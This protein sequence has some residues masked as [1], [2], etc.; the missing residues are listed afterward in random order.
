MRSASMA[1]P[2]V[3]GRRRNP[4]EGEYPF[5]TPVFVDGLT[6]RTDLNGRGARVCELCPRDT[7]GRIGIQLLCDAHTRVW[8]KKENLTALSFVEELD[9]D[10][11]RKMTDAERMDM[12]MYMDA[13]RGAKAIPG[14]KG[15][16]VSTFV[17]DH[18]LTE[19]EKAELLRVGQWGAN[20][21]P[22]EWGDVVRQIKNA[23]N[24][25]YP[26][27]WH[28]AIVNGDLFVANGQGNKS[29]TWSI[30]SDFSGLAAFSGDGIVGQKD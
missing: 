30:S 17:D 28:P 8:V 16:S 1:A 27:D 20:T 19:C 24:N 15:V 3:D 25:V 7:D 11:Y 22:L 5:D 2:V 29:A 18:P 12:R 10:K 6:A 9:E 14:M 21:S 26:R 4:G 23:R 13:S